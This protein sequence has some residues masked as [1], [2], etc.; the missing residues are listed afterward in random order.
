MAA[1]DGWTHWQR[2]LAI[3]NASVRTLYGHNEKRQWTYMD[4]PYA[5]AYSHGLLYTP[6]HYD[7][8]PDTIQTHVFRGSGKGALGCGLIARGI[9]GHTHT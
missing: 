9:L 7:N 2:Q 4:S 5:H 3:D 6:P 1:S 8:G